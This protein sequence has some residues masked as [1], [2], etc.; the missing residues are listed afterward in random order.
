V[1]LDPE[2][3]EVLEAMKLVQRLGQLMALLDDDAGL[4]SGGGCRLGDAVQAERIADLLDEIEHVVEPGDEGVNILPVE[5]RDEGL[6]E[7]MTDVV[8]DLVA[9]VLGV[10]QPSGQHLAFVVVLQ[11][12]LEHLGRGSHVLRVLHEKIEEALLARHQAESHRSVSLLWTMAESRRSLRSGLVG[13]G[14]PSR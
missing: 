8:G 14:A 12:A 4:L 13:C 6:F 9:L 10:A 1:D 11:H 2:F 5:R 7:P 3:L